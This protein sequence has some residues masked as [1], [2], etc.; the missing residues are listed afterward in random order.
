M[1][2]ADKIEDIIISETFGKGLRV[3]K[4]MVI[5]GAALY[6]MNSDSHILGVR[7]TNNLY[8]FQYEGKPAVVKREDVR[9]GRDLT[10]VTFNNGD[11]AYSGEFTTDDGKVV[12]VGGRNRLFNNQFSIFD[13]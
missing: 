2:F 5:G 11:V 10:Y 13:K 3:L 9:F 6:L 7:K 8:S 12:K 1:A 4:Y